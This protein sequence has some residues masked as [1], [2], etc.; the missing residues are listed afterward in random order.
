VPMASNQCF[1]VVDTEQ[2][3]NEVI[4]NDNQSW[5]SLPLP[6]LD[7]VS[8]HIFNP[9]DCLDLAKLAQVSKHYF[10]GVNTFMSRAGNRPGIE[11]VVAQQESDDSLGVIIHLIPSNS[12][13]YGFSDL[14]SARFER[15][16]KSVIHVKLN[17]FQDPIFEKV[18]DLL[19]AS[20]KNLEINGDLLSP[21]NLSLIAQLLRGSKAKH[22]DMQHCRVDESTVSSIIEIAGRARKI[23]LDLS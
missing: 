22:L 9:E 10:Y 5:E 21:E 6:A 2:P 8:Y 12:L 7:S 20:I 4:L 3:H 19:S 14:D 15:L 18:S 11:A 1:N 17:G 13:F 16:T 23:S